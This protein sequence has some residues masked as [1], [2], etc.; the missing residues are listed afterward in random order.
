MIKLYK[1]YVEKKRLAN[2]QTRLEIFKELDQVRYL[3]KR[4]ILEEALG[5]SEARR[6]YNDALWAEEQP[7]LS[8]ADDDLQKA[9]DELKAEFDAAQTEF[10]AT[11]VVTDTVTTDKKR[12]KG[13]RGV[14]VT[15]L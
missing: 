11:Q 10:N 2:L 12:K 9:L 13:L 15:G 6:L 8:N 4:F 7:L 14:G 1:E 5:L 3:S